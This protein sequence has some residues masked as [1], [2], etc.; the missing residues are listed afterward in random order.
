MCGWI[1]WSGMLCLATSFLTCLGGCGRSP[2]AEKAAQEAKRETVVSHGAPEA[3]PDEDEKPEDAKKTDDAKKGAADLELAESKLRFAIPAAWKKVPP[4]TNMIEAEF[5]IPKSGK[6]EFDGRLTL[7]ASG[8]SMD[9]NLKR[10][11][12]EF[13]EGTLRDSKDESLMLAGKKAT[14]IERSGVWH[15]T[16]FSPAAPRKNY[17]LVVVVLPLS[18]DRSFF[19]KLTGPQET[20]AAHEAEFRAF[21]N[22][23]KPI[24]EKK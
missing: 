24:D 17:R 9:D 10:W 19:I 2:E 11:E 22:S 3:L 5:Q 1:R 6:D 16:R 15:G 14:W 7:M 23:A 4:P 20:I 21:V 12:G 18:D 8:G 13:E